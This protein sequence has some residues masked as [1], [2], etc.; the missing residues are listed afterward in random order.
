MQAVEVRAILSATDRTG[1]VF[2]Q[3]A[4]RHAAALKGVN[5]GEA[6]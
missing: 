1:G 4:N 5:R 3:N 2:S 6:V